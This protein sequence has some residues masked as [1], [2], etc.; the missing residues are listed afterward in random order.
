MS[1]FIIVL[2]ICAVSACLLVYGI[3][4]ARLWKELITIYEPQISDLNECSSQYV[5]EQYVKEEI[6]TYQNYRRLE[7][8]IEKFQDGSVAA[9]FVLPSPLIYCYTIAEAIKRSFTDFSSFWAYVV[10]IVIT[11]IIIAIPLIVIPKVFPSPKFDKTRKELFENYASSG[12]TPNYP[13]SEEKDF[14]NFI[15]SRHHW[16]LFSIRNI[17][18]TRYILRIIGCVLMLIALIISVSRL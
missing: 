17:E 3:S 14:N 11:F 5:I 9:L 1:T 10:S 18:Q 13:I 4:N 16:F 12:A 15:R 8:E 7:A 6:L 2:I